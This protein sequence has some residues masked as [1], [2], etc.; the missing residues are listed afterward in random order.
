MG[1]VALG[2]VDDEHVGGDLGDAGGRV[3]EGVYQDR[4]D[5]DTGFG[6]WDPPEV[7]LHELGDQDGLVC[8]HG[9]VLREE[10]L[11][12]E[13]DRSQ[14]DGGQRGKGHDY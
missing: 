6:G 5:H 11:R 13:G 2:E 10:P 14:R 3:I 9:E 8:A 1:G 12:E 4:F 7:L